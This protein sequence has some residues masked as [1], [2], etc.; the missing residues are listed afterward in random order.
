M[1][2]EPP[3]GE[4]G[5]E[6]TRRTMLKVTGV[7]SLGAGSFAGCLDGAG[8]SSQSL[9][10]RSLGYGGVPYRLTGAPV[11]PLSVV[12]PG[13]GLVAHWTLDGSDGAVTDVAGG[14]NGTVRGTPQRGVPGVYDSTAYAFGDGS[15]DYVEV[16]DATALRP[17]TELTFSGWF[18]T[19]SGANAQ[20]LVQK[21]DA[22][23]GSEGY[24]ADV[25]TPNSLRAHVAVESGRASVN[26]WGVA[27]HDGEWH[28]VA[29]TW[30]GN[31]L[32]LYLDG[33]EVD[34]DESQSGAVVHSD[35]PLYV[36]RGDNGYTSYYAMNGAIDDV[37]LYDR[38]LGTDEVVSLFEG[39][40]TT[41]PETD[42]GPEPDPE[43]EPE[44]EPAPEPEP[45][46]E[47]A[48]EPE[49]APTDPSAQP[50]PAARWE[51]AETTGAT[52]ADSA[53]STDGFVR[54]SPAL[55]TDGVF[56][57]SA[58]SF[59][60]APGDYVEMP[61][62]AS[63]TP[64]TELTFCGWFRTESG[65]N[66][67]TLVQKAD[68]RFGSEGYAADVQT[69]NSL[70]AHVA[71]ESGRASVNPWGVATHDGEWHHVA[72]TWDGN[73]LV[74]YLDGEE[75]DR[76]ESQSGAVVHSDRPLY[77]GRGDNGYTSYYAMNGA[78]DDVRV[79]DA[80]LTEGEVAAVL[81]GGTNDEPTPTDPEPPTVPNDEFGEG[82][83]G[84]HGYG[85]VEGS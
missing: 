10:P 9:G 67:Q 53:G 46:Q 56:G 2:T 8:V 61:N 28:H 18:R 76:D 27:T 42:P 60:G 65:A 22:R 85:G 30:D 16:P 52:I 4:D 14:N 51:F 63:L 31:A 79:Y 34:R 3:P 39:T 44:Q 7:S 69:P 17:E 50:A 25:Q 71:V 81:D 12:G 20:T 78:I 45:E 49:P 80:A 54:G 70:R 75:V 13:D 11:P 36:G 43:P 26:P 35:R 40:V 66:E 21:A 62:S 6:L 82:G 59:G 23:F 33:E 72:Y 5:F 15:D 29:Y 37:R 58:I 57:T 55:D 48:P 24:A 32:V 41:E 77:V 38:A 19:D 64:A 1:P 74:L 73:A 84:S 47:P 83:Y 68:A